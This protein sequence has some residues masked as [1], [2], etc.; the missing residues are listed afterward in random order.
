[1]PT[2]IPVVDADFKLVPMQAE[3]LADKS[4]DY[5]GGLSQHLTIYRDIPA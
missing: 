4:R 3:I 5:S 2:N 1:M